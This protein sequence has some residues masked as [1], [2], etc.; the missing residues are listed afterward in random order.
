MAPCRAP[1]ACS[2]LMMGARISR[3]G[4]CEPS[5]VRCSL[6]RW[7]SNL[8]FSCAGHQ[9]RIRQIARAAFIL[10]VFGCRAESAERCVMITGPRYYLVADN[11]TWSTKTETGYRCIR[12]FRY[13][14]VEFEGVTLISQPRSGWVVCRA[15]DLYILPKM[16]SWERIRLTWKSRKIR[17]TST[18]HV[19]VSVV[20]AQL[21]FSRRR[22][23]PSQPWI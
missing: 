6:D 5:T 7:R 3:F 21:P 16:T 12:G 19:F 2:S 1:P 8:A 23:S 4:V 14:N 22:E 9:M 15:G 10:L 11:V 17:G 18:I 13:A 20:G